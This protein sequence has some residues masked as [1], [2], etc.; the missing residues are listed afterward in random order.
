MQ[1][2]E[3]KLLLKYLFRFLLIFFYIFHINNYVFITFIFITLL[4]YKDIK[5]GYQRDKR[6]INKTLF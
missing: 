2:Y 5:K 3:I 6:V 1:L 4:L